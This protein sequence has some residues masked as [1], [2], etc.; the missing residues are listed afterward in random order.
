MRWQHPTALYILWHER[1]P[2][3]PCGSSTAQ[4]IEELYS[5]TLEDHYGE[6]AHHYS[7][8]ENT[9][10]A[11]K[12]LQL[13]GQQ[14]VQRSANVEAIGHFTTALEL[15]QTLPDTP[16][17]GEQELLLQTTLGSALIM[18]KGWAAVEK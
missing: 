8:S 11:V 5:A 13:A 16:E 17:R 18:T 1:Q 4:A 15:L 2:S 6:L 3:R 14:A 7:R 10:K 9:E 12:Y